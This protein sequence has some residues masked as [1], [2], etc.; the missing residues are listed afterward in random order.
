MDNT[1]EQGRAWFAILA[2]IPAILGWAG[3]GLAVL[4]AP[5][6][7]VAP[8]PLHWAAIAA[9]G[10]YLIILTFVVGPVMLAGV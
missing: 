8:D 1:T 7:D 10:W 2:G 4:L 5:H 9:G 3:Y 6:L